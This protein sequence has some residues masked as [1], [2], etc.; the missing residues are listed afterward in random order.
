MPAHHCFSMWM[1]SL[2]KRVVAIFTHS[3]LGD[4]YNLEQT[5]IPGSCR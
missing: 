3:A 5:D 4:L 2:K 1:K